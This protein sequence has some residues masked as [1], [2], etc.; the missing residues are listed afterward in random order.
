MTCLIQSRGTHV[1]KYRE[2]QY[3]KTFLLT[4]D[5]GSEVVAKLPNPNAGPNVLTTASEVATMDYVRNVID[6]SVPRVLGWSCRPSN[7]VGCEYVIMEKARGSALG[8][9]W[10][11]LPSASKHKFIK[12]VV[13][14]EAKLA[15]VSFPEHGCIYYARDLPITCHP[16]PTPLHG[17]EL[18]KFRIGPVVNPIFWSDGRAEMELSRGPWHGLS[19]YATSI[20]DNEK[21]WALRHAR[22]RMNYYRSNTDPEMPNEYLEL[23]EKYL[24]VVPNLTQCEPDSAGLLQPTLWHIDLHLNNIYVDLNTETITEIIDWQNTTVAPLLLQARVPR[25]IQHISALPLGWVMPEKPEN[26]ETLPERDRVRADK[27]YES[28]L[29]HKYYEV[30]T[31]KRNPQHYAA[32]THNESWKS[33]VIQP[34][35]SITGAWS[36]REVFRLRSSLMAVEEHWPEL[37]T[38]APCPVTF[39]EEEK[40]LQNEEL[41]NRDYIEQLMAEFQ[42]AGILP[43]DGIV[44]PE[45]YDIVQ[46]TNRAQK[47]RFMSLAENEEQKGWM[48]KI[49][50]YQDRPEEA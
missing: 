34:I 7:P 29:C 13:D 32:I 36:S 27:L 3:N 48:D 28:A 41:E 20:G 39:T 46:K 44:D 2:G 5:N 42:D 9:A 43:I 45:D 24:Q 10:Y 22:P 38:T 4:L 11:S 23:I 16:N 1:M 25:M 21:A 30:L 40:Q 18:R 50:P 19:E 37:P 14:I 8:D 49:W 35:Q 12:Q 33:P 15:S 17:D 6:I 47:E 31:A 26:Y